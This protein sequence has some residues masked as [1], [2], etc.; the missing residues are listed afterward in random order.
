MGTQSWPSVTAQTTGLSMPPTSACFQRQQSP[1]TS[2]RYQ[3]EVQ[4]ALPL[5]SLGYEAPNP[6]ML[7]WYKFAYIP[8]TLF[9]LGLS[10]LLALKHHAFPSAKVHTPERQEWVTKGKPHKVLSE[11][12]ICAE[13]HSYLSWV[14]MACGWQVE[15]SWTFISRWLKNTTSRANTPYD[16]LPCWLLDND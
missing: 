2:P 8:H 4:T 14:S 6:V 7:N 11:F 5:M 16:V 10:R 1:R 13:P 15:H 9:T 12:M 3:A